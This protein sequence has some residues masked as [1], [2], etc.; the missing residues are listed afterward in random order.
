MDTNVPVQFVYRVAVCGGAS[1][2]CLELHLRE[3]RE[4]PPTAITDTTAR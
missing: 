1:S 4:P 2:N 3:S